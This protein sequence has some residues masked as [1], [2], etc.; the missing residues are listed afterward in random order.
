MATLAP[1][2]LPQQAARVRISRPPIVL[3]LMAGW[4]SGR[5]LATFLRRESVSKCLMPRPPATER[6]TAVAL[7]TATTRTMIMGMV[8]QIRG[9]TR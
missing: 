1:R 5:S 7:F 4:A 9:A 8:L 6:R 3:V 2:P